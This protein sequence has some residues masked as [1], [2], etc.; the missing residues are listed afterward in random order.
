M[1]LTVFHREAIYTLQFNVRAF[2]NV[3]HWPWM[4]LYYKVKPLLK[5][6]ETEKELAE[7][8]DNFEKMKIDLAA[9]L[10]KKK[11]LEQKLVAMAQEKNDL[12]MA[13]QSVST[14]L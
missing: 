1:T 9:A 3:K 14:L 8:K 13:S 10:A 6:A 12:A 4:K 5:S 2:C 11:E 7:M